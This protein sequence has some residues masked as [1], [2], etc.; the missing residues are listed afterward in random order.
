VVVADDQPDAGRDALAQRPDEGRPGRALVVGGSEL[1]AEHPPLTGRRDAG[2]DE[3][4]HR[5]DPTVLA[6]LDV[7]VACASTEAPL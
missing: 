4:R 3:R 7:R 2:R 1:E 5:H 6:D